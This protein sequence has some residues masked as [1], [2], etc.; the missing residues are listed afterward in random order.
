MVSGS[1]I[2]SYTRLTE[3]TGAVGPL[4]TLAGQYKFYAVHLPTLTDVTGFPIIIDG[5]NAVN[6]PT[7]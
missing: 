3:H 1:G 5:N 6:D 7:R 2:H 4:G